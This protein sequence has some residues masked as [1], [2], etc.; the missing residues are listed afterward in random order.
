[1]EDHAIYLSN[2]DPAVLSIVFAVVV[3]VQTIP[4][5][6]Y[7][8]GISKGYAMLAQIQCRFGIVPFKFH[9][10]TVDA[11]CSYMQ[12]L[13]VPGVTA[14]GNGCSMGSALTFDFLPQESLH[15]THQSI[16]PHE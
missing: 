9:L 16:C 10:D 11:L 2:A 7:M 14:I 4:V 12:A 1:M 15:V 13:F 3:V 5:K 6:K 8:Y